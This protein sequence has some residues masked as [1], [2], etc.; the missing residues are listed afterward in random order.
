MPRLC[1]FARHGSAA[2]D[3]EARRH[4]IGASG[5]TIRP[6]PGFP[7]P[8]DRRQG[9]IGSRADDDGL[10]SGETSDRVS[11]RSRFDEALAR[12]A[13]VTANERDVGAV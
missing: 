2:Y 6:R 10:A 12:Q 4:A 8:R 3:H 11:G 1:K 5:F 13:S 7:E 9:E